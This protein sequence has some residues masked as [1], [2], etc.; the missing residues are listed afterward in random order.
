MFICILPVFLYVDT[1]SPEILVDLL[2]TEDI[3][4]AFYD[5][6]Q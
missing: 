2:L 6:Q 3:I 5:M 4:T 1:A